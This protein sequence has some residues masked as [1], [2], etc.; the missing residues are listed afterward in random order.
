[1]SDSRNWNGTGEQI[2]SALSEALQSGDFK[3]LNDLVSQTVTDAINA[4]GKHV[5]S[6]NTTKQW[7]SGAGFEDADARS[8]SMPTPLPLSPCG[9]SGP[10][11]GSASGR[12]G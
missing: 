5:S 12:T 2:K 8:R 4:A 10:W 6:G 1:M 11:K 7:S 3:N 9:G